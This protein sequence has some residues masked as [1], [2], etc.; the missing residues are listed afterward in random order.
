MKT[1][2][3]LAIAVAVA[4][5]C[6]AFTSSRAAGTDDRIES[7]AKKTY[8]YR[9]YLKDDDIKIVSKDGAVTLTGS[10]SEDSHKSLA[11]D[12]VKGLP[13]VKSVDNQLEVKGEKSTAMSDDWISAKV[14]AALLFHRSTSGK[15]QVFVQD[16][17]V[18][19]KGAAYSTAQKDLATQYA[20][21]V[22]GVKN[23]VNEMTVVSTEPPK[24][25]IGEKIDDA[26]VTA[27]VKMAL[28]SHR[29]TSA[30]RTDVETKDGI[31]M[32]RGKAKNQ[33]EKDLVTK[34]A[35]DINGV[36]LVQNEMTIG[37]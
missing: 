16:G 30:L 12:T 11:E 20:R 27:Q 13:G 1:N 2:K 22:D 24:P 35:E 17:V 34:L 5:A 33:A 14:K 19:L 4:V 25:T 23:V 31:V 8:V 28:L 36:K 37:G 6:G 15:T 21:D 7:S 18:T 3:V 10:V 29:S 9:T 26:S 32:L